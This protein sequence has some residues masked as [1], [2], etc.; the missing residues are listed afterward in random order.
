MSILRTLD[1]LFVDEIGQVPDEIVSVIEIV[2]RRVR[3]SQVFFDVLLIVSTMDHMKLQPVRGSP[4]SS[5]FS[6]NHML[7]YG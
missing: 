7:Q 4:I 3:D 1:V 2:L 6:C 5:I